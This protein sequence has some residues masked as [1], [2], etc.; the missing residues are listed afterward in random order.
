MA[1][2]PER[3]DALLAELG[4]RGVPIAPVIGEVLDRADVAVV[5]ERD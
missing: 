4:A 5:I 3:I 2:P 1:C